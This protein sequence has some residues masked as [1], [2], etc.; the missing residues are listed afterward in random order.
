MIYENIG[1]DCKLVQILLFQLAH[2]SHQEQWS[3]NRALSTL[4]QR[5]ER[6]I[7]LLE[8]RWRKLLLLDHLDIDLEVY[9]IVAAC[10][11]HNFCFCMMILMI[12]IYMMGQ[13]T[14]MKHHPVDGRAEAKRTHLMHIVCL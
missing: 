2:N 6:A 9:I 14:V 11:L 10:V 5:I 8:G 1:T 13:L 4:R 12:C 3:F 7:P